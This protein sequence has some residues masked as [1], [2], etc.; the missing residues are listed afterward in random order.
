MWRKWLKFALGNGVEAIAVTTGVVFIVLIFLQVLFRYLFQSPISWSEELIM[1]FFQWT[2]FLGAAIS[3]RSGGHF[4]LSFL[5]R[6][7]ST[8][9]SSYV[10]ILC[11]FLMA[12][13]AF[14]MLLKGWGMVVLTRNSTFATM[15]IS[16][17]FSYAAI[18]ISGAL[19]IIYLIPLFVQKVKGRERSQR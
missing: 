3:M 17:A 2:I 6:H 12:M 11:L 19:M 1:L 7:L 15:G 16:R 13:V 10:D 8:R 14:M 4:R 18:P 9:V 5:A